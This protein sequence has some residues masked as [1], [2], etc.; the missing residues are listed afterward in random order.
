MA[1]RSNR[2][3]HGTFNCEACGRLTRG[4]RD[5]AEIGLC[6]QDDNIA[7]LYN[8]LQDEDVE[9]LQDFRESF[10]EDIKVIREKGGTPDGDALELEDW[11]KNN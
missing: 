3:T 7:A 5:S 8:S 6:E 11:Y 10:A 9:T 4:S 1:I 2:F